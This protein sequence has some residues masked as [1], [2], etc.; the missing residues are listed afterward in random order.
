MAS[1]RLTV[2]IA[3]V[4]VTVVL[5]A[6]LGSNGAAQ[7]ARRTAQDKTKLVCTLSDNQTNAAIAAFAGL[8][9]VFHHDRCANCH[10][11]IDPFAPRGHVDIRQE[12]ERYRDR[13]QVAISA[14]DPVPPAANIDAAHAAIVRYLNG[15]VLTPGQRGQIMFSNACSVCHDPPRGADSWRMPPPPDTFHDKNALKLCSHIHTN[16]LTG[17]PAEFDDHM[18]TDEFV[19][20]GF[21]GTRGLNGLGESIAS[22]YTPK[23]IVAPNHSATLGHVRAWLDAQRNEFSPNPECGCRP[24]RYAFDW[25]AAWELAAT[26][27]RSS[28][29]GGAAARTKIPIKFKDDGTF[30][31]EGSVPWNPMAQAMSPGTSCTARSES[32][33]K[34]RVKGRVTREGVME[35]DGV[36][37][38]DAKP[39][40]VTCQTRD[41]TRSFSA[42]MSVAGRPVPFAMNMKAEV[43]TQVRK[44]F[45]N[46]GSKVT[47]NVTL[48]EER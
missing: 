14:G 44:D 30:T 20:V 13:R 48:L 18:R 37:E 15:G 36:T 32:K 38:L 10:H 25:S 3:L 9:P 24:F 19:L 43:G 4:L 17:T 39:T 5:F 47:I 28:V 8:M 45:G 12:F 23:P 6:A 41:G 42:P 26:G 31:G 2:G 35:I 34:F 27:H 11:K 33:M 21:K 1:R 46:A 22:P 16:D 40:T 7:D 29:S